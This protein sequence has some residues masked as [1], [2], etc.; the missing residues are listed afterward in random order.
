M[1]PGASTTPS[2]DLR[3]QII[4][5]C[6]F[7]S[8]PYARLSLVIAKEPLGG[9]RAIVVKTEDGTREALLS[10]AASSLNEALQ[11]LHVK[12]AE[13]VQNHISSNGFALVNT[14]KERSFALDDDN[15]DD[16]DYDDR[17]HGSDS[18]T[19]TLDEGESLSDD[20]TVSVCSVGRAK[21]RGR[22]ADKSA[23]ASSARRKTKRQGRARSR[24]PWRSA[25]SAR[26]RSRSSCSG[27]SGYE[28]HYDPPAIP[29]RRPPILHG[30]SQ[31]M[32]PRPPPRPPQGT[33]PFIPRGHPAPPPPPPPGPRPFFTRAAYGGMTSMPPPPVRASPFSG[34]NK[35]PLHT[36]NHNSNDNNPASTMMPT[37]TPA[38]PLSHHP[39]THQYQNRNSYQNQCHQPEPQPQ[40]QPQQQPQP[41]HD[42]ILHIRWRHHG[43][44]R[45]VQQTS[46]ITVRGLQ[47]SALSFVKQQGASFANGPSPR[48]SPLPPPPPPQDGSINIG[49]DANTI[50]NHGHDHGHGHGGTN[51]AARQQTPDCSG[52]RAAVRAV[53]VDGVSYDLTGWAGDDLGR[54][55]DGLGSPSSSSSSSSSSPP[56]SSS[57]TTTSSTTITTL[58]SAS[59]AVASGEGKQ[60]GGPGGRGATT[61]T[62]TM[63][64]FEVDV[65]S[66]D[67]DGLPGNNNMPATATTTTPPGLYG[68]ADPSRARPTTTSGF[69]YGAPSTGGN[70]FSSCGGAGSYAPQAVTAGAVAAAAAAA[71]APPPSALANGSRTGFALS[72]PGLVASI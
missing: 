20:E 42:L 5:N 22:K 9:L 38:S 19:V 37:T 52:L 7:F 2:I 41:L 30:F 29:S 8:K 69:G 4:E 13:A 1:A 54:L 49:S 34:G 45:I 14:A 68:G 3:A 21:R 15:D 67:D 18:S 65:W 55:L 25:G 50:D 51:P 63:P 64:R 59:T 70:G 17:A 53:V 71:A 60:Q 32:P 40:P 10:E 11:A 57:S 33:F 16:D 58:S 27:S 23:K 46:Q 28:L 6:E 43:E 47:Q 72:S 61:R 66:D 26:S 35:A 62:R 36:T 12:S 24:S 31:R 44:R 56:F 39:A 48:S